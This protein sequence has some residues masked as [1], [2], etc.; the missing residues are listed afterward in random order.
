MN[1]EINEQ[2]PT[3]PEAEVTVDEQK[4]AESEAEVTVDEPKKNIDIGGWLKFGW[5]IFKTDVLKFMVSMLIVGVVSIITCLIL[6]GPMMVGFFKCIL[7]KSRG[8]DFEY[9]ELFDGVKTQFLPSFVLMAVVTVCVIIVSAILA[10]IPVI[11]QIAGTVLGIA[12]SLFT[13]YMYLQ[14]AEMEETLEVGKLVELGKATLNKLKS[15]Y[16]MFLVWALVVYILGFVGVIVCCVGALATYSI[17]MIAVTK[18][19]ND[20]IKSED[21]V[22][23]VAEEVAVEE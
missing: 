14:L 21:E 6:S 5:K 18:S 1:D 11:G 3:E 17:A 16:G 20:V 13:N 23:V 10:I 8:D 15:D 22:A 2:D 12:I 7:K 4:P 19:Y 9:G